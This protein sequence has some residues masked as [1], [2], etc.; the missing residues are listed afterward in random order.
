[1]AVVQKR[2]GIYPLYTALQ[3]TS[4]PKRFGTRLSGSRN[5]N[6]QCPKGRKLN[7]DLGLHFPKQVKGLQRGEVVQVG[8]GELLAK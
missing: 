6:S 4:I 5:S 2:F 7:P 3:G 8:G 1:M